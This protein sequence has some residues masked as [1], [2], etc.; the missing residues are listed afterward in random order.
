[1]PDPAHADRLSATTIHDL[2]AALT[3]IKAQ[4]QMLGRWVRR[5]EPTDAD[6]AL[7]RVAVIEA[8]VAKLVLELDALK[9]TP[10]ERTA[11][12]GDDR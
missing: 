4:S 5:H 3:V 12:P 1:M 8:M 11:P 10:T 9:T 7:A 2:R 6:A